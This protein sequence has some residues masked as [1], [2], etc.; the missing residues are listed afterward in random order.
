MTSN[1]LD[2]F[3]FFS[4]VSREQ[5]SE[6]ESFAISQ[7]YERGQVVFQNNEPAKNLYALAG[8]EVDLAILFREEV[9][10][11][12][13]KYEE[14]IS[15]R[16]ELFEKPI[17]IERVKPFEIFGWSALVSPEKMTATA[18]CASD[19]EIILVPAADLKQMFGR[20]PE[21]GYLLTRR[22]SSIIAKRLNS[23]TEKLV[24]AWCMSFDTGQI[25]TV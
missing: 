1:A 3:P 5:L 4:G 23:R 9:V 21:L 11:K 16:V 14:Y 2:R 24:D 12:D 7:Q 19:C 25:T 8:G 20:D 18:R 17:V 22:I 10:T 6:I 15:T 13:I